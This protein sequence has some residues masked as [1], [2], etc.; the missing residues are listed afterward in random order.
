MQISITLKSEARAQARAA[1]ELRGI[2]VADDWFGPVFENAS[3]VH[4]HFAEGIMFCV[5]INDTEGAEYLYPYS[6]IARI[7]VV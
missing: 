7:K 4:D 2:P 1:L 3:I 6:D 5:G